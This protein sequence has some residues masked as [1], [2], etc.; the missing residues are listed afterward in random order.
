MKEPKEGYK[1]IDIL[2]K[3]NYGHKVLFSSVEKL[4]AYNFF[5]YTNYYR[6]SV[7]LRLVAEDHK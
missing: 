3:E 7:F 6:F 4:Q 5:K 2:Q 1:F